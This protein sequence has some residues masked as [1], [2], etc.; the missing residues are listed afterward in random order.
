MVRRVALC[1][2]VQHCALFGPWCGAV[3]VGLRAAP[4]TIPA[5]SACDC[6]WPDLAH[7]TTLTCDSPP[8]MCQYCMDAASYMFYG[9]ENSPTVGCLTEGR[10]TDVC[11][12]VGEAMQVRA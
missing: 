7:T 1:L 3:R 8:K 11:L 12:K 9:P 5:L 2:V 4:P 6:K 10:N